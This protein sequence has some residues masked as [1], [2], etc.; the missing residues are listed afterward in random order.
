MCK[1]VDYELKNDGLLLIYERNVTCFQYEMVQIAV[2]LL[3]T[4]MKDC[5]DDLLFFV[6]EMLKVDGEWF[7]LIN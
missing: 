1:T 4:L 5:D 3:T 7:S 6:N 2:F